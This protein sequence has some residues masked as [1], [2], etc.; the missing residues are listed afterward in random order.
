MTPA[1]IRENGRTLGQHGCFLTGWRYDSSFMAKPENQ[2][3]F[4]DMIATLASRPA[5]ACLRR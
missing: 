1:Q 3:A 5:P 4:R 2:Q